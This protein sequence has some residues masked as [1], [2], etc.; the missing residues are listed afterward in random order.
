LSVPLE[1]LDKY[2]TT[3]LDFWRLGPKRFLARLQHDPEKYMRPALFAGTT[4]L[5]LLALES[6]SSQ[7]L[8][9]DAERIVRLKM[10]PA[11]AFAGEGL[12]LII[13]LLLLQAFFYRVIS[14]LW[15]IRGNA[16]IV[17]LCEFQ[18][19]ALALFVPF[20]MLDV[21]LADPFMYLLAHGASLWQLLS[22]FLLYILAGI[23]LFLVYQNRGIA[24][25]NKVTP[26]RML[27]GSL[28]WGMPLAAT[29]G[30]IAVA[31]KHVA[32]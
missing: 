27:A 11:E 18:S 20:A 6:I 13:T 1:L 19:Y 8:A 23:A 3:F 4:L 25:L 26:A 32:R 9:P 31:I 21:V 12:V 24:E 7:L 16:T 14:P 2:Q 30:M 15:P 17:S 5:V 29:L 28:L 22:P 10:P